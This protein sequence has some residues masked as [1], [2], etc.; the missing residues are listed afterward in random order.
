MNNLLSANFARIKTSKVFWLLTAAVLIISA[1]NCIDDGS[2]AVANPNPD[3]PLEYICFSI[4]PFMSIV[5]AAF[6]SLFIGTE[7]SDGTVRNKVIIGQK[8]SAI[9][10]ANL[11]T[12]GVASLVMCLAWHIGSLAGLPFL[13]VWK[14]GIAAWLLYVLLS[15]MFTVA[16][17]AVFCLI[18]HLF[19]NKAICAVFAII[20][21]LAL[22][23]AGSSLYNSL[24]EPETLRDYVI[25]SSDTGEMSIAP[26]EEMPNPSY[27][28]EPMRTACKA[29]LNSLPTG[30]AILMASVTDSSE[31]ALT[32][33]LLQPCASVAIVLLFTAVGVAAFKRKDIK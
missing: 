9:Y 20:L 19:T 27:I 25:I 21:A 15:M 6:V 28:A 14:M 30:Q 26:G 10:L 13:G 23:L 22:I 1:G 17:C 16:L 8:R 33:P 3:P 24:L 11:I 2:R 29:A 5:I 4:G 7:Y 32:M 18:S 31:E 12:C